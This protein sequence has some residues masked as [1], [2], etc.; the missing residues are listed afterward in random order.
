MAETTLRAHPHMIQQL[1]GTHTGAAVT[2]SQLGAAASKPAFARTL[3]GNAMEALVNEINI[4]H[5]AT[6]AGFT[7][8]GGA[9]KIDFIGW[10]RFEGLTF[11]LT[12]E[13]AVGAHAVRPYVQGTPGAMIFTYTLPIF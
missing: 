5:P 6:D 3:S 12:T 10:G 7:Q 8:V 1:G 9:S 2:M 13:A 11:E 4:A